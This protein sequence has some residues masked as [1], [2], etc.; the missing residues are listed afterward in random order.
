[1]SLRG[2]MYADA[3]VNLAL[4][5]AIGLGAPAIAEGFGLDSVLPIL[6]LAG[7]AALSGAVHGVTGV[8]RSVLAIKV[9]VLLDATAL[10][11][12]LLLA[13]INPLGAPAW[14]RAALAFVG[15]LALTMGALKVLALRSARTASE[16]A[17]TSAFSSPARC[18][19]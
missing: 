19:R 6:G 10:L 15:V 14:V 7:V 8:T 9:M 16:N 5:I 17:A 13:A 2:V 4:A 1:M 18:A 3:A 12:A 11:L